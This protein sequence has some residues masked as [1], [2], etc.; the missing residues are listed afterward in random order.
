M[1]SSVN[2]P[3]TINPPEDNLKFQQQVWSFDLKT[4]QNT[5]ILLSTNPI[6]FYFCKQCNNDVLCVRSQLRKFN[7][8]KTE[9]AK[10]AVDGVGFIAI[11]CRRYPHAAAA[12]T[13]AA[14]LAAKKGKKKGF[15]TCD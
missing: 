6:Y 12:T 1:S 2:A 4:S 3:R 14:A 13:A 10:L 8:S 5:T 9:G 7:C 15:L 11:R